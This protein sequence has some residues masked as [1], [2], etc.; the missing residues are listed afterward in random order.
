MKRLH[1]PNTGNRFWLTGVIGMVLMLLA[2]PAGAAGG[3]TQV[4]PGSGI[5]A[6]TPGFQPGGIILTA[7]DKA[8]LWVY[9]IDTD[10]RYPLPDTHP[11]GTNCR[12]S[13][14][15]RWITYVNADEYT[16]AKMR[17]DG[18]QR[19]PLID[20]AADVEWWTATRLLVWT[21]EHQAYLQDEGGGDQQWLNVRGVTSIQ[22]GGTHA[23]LVEPTET[24]FQHSLIDLATRDVLNAAQEHFILGVDL[25]YYDASAWSPDGQWLGYVEPVQQANGFSSEIYGIRPGDSAPTQWTHLTDT[26]GAVRIDGRTPGTL[27]WSPDGTQIAFWVIPLKGSSPDSDTGSAMI[28]I[29]NIA[30]GD[31]RAYC[32]FTTIEHTPT[33]PRLIWSPDGTHLTFGGNVPGDNKGYL[34]LA[35]D[36]ASGVFTELSDGIFPALGSPDAIAWGLPPS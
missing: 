35:M 33:T 4:C 34:L 3:M 28:H 24:G 32:G 15:A 26:Y 10:R 29:L 19:T 2:R 14:D 9:N 25:P 8:S 1:I 11:C 5:Q 22:P 30:T 27:S 23:V 20:Y 31:I 21:P 36:T 18:T 7:F 12:L 16:Y 17:L 6:R 13:P